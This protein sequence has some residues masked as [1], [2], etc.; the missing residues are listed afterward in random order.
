METSADQDHLARFVLSAGLTFQPVHVLI[1][2][3]KMTNNFS[4]TEKWT[5]L[6]INLAWYVISIN[7]FEPRHDKTNKVRY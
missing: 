2:S 5:S 6:F 1:F 7:S 4:S 3:I